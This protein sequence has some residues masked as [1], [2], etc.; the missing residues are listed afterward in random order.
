MSLMDQ[1]KAD[2]KAIVESDEGFSIPITIETPDH[3]TSL[4]VRALVSNH[5]L[6]IDPENGN[7]INSKNVHFSVPESSL[8]DNGYVTRDLNKE[9]NLQGHLVEFTDGSGITGKFVI[10]ECW[11]NQTL[12]FLVFE[13]GMYGS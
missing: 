11:P 9:V 3:V 5:N 7:F 8:T 2:V 12:G 6:A 13:L 4:D 10:S 1:A